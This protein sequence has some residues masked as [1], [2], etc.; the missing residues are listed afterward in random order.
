KDR[1]VVG[2]LRIDPELEQTARAMERAW[3]AA[4]A[5]KFA[6]VANVD[7]HHVGLAVQLDRI[8]SI[9]RLDL[10]IGRRDQVVDVHRDGL[11]HAVL[12]TTLATGDQRGSS[13]K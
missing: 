5:G 1:L 2:A 10:A 8:G 13:P 9:K 7:E 12:L 3:H 11:R 6:H 4:L